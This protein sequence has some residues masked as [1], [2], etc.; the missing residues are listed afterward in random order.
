MAIEEKHVALKINS[1]FVELDREY[2]ELKNDFKDIKSFSDTKFYERKNKIGKLM[3]DAS[4]LVYTY[5]SLL[6]EINSE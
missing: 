4:R 1:I 5:Q 6:H 3:C 2:E